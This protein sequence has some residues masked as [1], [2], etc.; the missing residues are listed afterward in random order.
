MDIRSDFSS[1]PETVYKSRT[2]SYLAKTEGALLRLSE[3]TGEV[4]R[5]QYQEAKR[6]G[7]PEY[8]QFFLNLNRSQESAD[9][10]ETLSANAFP[11]SRENEKKAQKYLFDNYL[12]R[13]VEKPTVAKAFAGYVG[14]SVT[15]SLVATLMGISGV[16]TGPAALTAL[17]I[18]R[19]L[20][21]RTNDIIGIAPLCGQRFLKEGKKF[22]ILTLNT[23][24]SQ[25]EIMNSINGLKDSFVRSKALARFLTKENPGIIL[26]QEAFHSEA[27]QTNIIP[28]LVDNKYSVIYTVKPEKTLGLSAGL[29][30]ASKHPIREVA[31]YKYRHPEGV[32]KRAKKG[33]LM[34]IVEVKEGEFIC[35]ANTHMQGK[36]T[37]ED[38]VLKRKSQFIKAK[39]AVY[40]FCEQSEYPIKD[41]FFC[42]DFNT[43]RFKPQ[44]DGKLNMA[45]FTP[46]YMS[47]EEGLLKKDKTTKMRLKDLTVPDVKRSFKQF[48]KRKLYTK[49]K[50]EN[51]RIRNN[52]SGSEM[53]TTVDTDSFTHKFY[54]TLVIQS[55]WD[56]IHYKES[57]ELSE[58]LQR[59]HIIKLV[60]AEVYG[61][62]RPKFLKSSSLSLSECEIN[63]ID[64]IIKKRLCKARKMKFTKPQCTDHI[65]LAQREENLF[66][67]KGYTYQIKVPDDSSD[68]NALKVKLK[69]L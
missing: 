57:K 13:K 52:E 9:E 1:L 56:D 10:V 42:G 17:G 8:Y 27:V 43:S 5:E 44:E 12:I 47:M 36:F 41:V 40:E 66:S 22:S 7:K 28:S 53:G 20:Q 23:G 29:L 58:K 68:H 6:G 15:L 19:A 11:I 55:V 64:K 33:V 38:A 2:A 60:K 48:S 50:S 31:F 35:I 14:E 30:I 51:K 62:K 32:D 67:E 69:Q 24:L 65:C 59:R 46:D 61:N 4:V 26:L 34:A 63:K 3:G 18:R 25:S 49:M 54:L 39:R 45:R 37:G 21:G 16:V